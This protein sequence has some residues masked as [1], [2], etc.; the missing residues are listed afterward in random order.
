MK[1][2]F[3]LFV[4]SLSLFAE[5]E[6]VYSPTEP[7][8]KELLIPAQAQKNNLFK[9]EFYQEKEVKEDSTSKEIETNLK[10]EN[11]IKISITEKII[12]DDT[13]EEFIGDKDFDK[14][15]L[16]VQEKIMN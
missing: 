9:K 8:G 6:Y 16:G 1:L 4:F 5:K 12:S 11:N 3:C 13:E 15:P 10:E 7:T 2:I 14:I